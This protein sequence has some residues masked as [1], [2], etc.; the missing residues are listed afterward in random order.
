MYRCHDTHPLH[1]GVL[2]DLSSTEAQCG[3][4][5]QQLGYE[6]LCLLCDVGPVLI[7]KLILALLDAVKQVTL[8][9]EY[10]TIS[11]DT[12]QAFFSFIYLSFMLFVAVAVILWLCLYKLTELNTY[13]CDRRGGLRLEHGGWMSVPGRFCRFLPGPSHSRYH[14]GLWRGGCRSAG[15]RGSPQGSKGHSA[16]RRM[17][18]HRWTPPLLLEPCTLQSHTEKKRMEN[19]QA[20]SDCCIRY[21]HMCWLVLSTS[22]HR[23]Y[24][25]LRKG[26]TKRQTTHSPVKTSMKRR[27]KCAAA[28]LS[29]ISEIWVSVPNG[30][31]IPT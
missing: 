12:L 11:C 3:V 4:P 20:S 23:Y 18:P 26:D 24:Y 7:W 17:R 19:T 30:C 14:S 6:I 21:I 31:W 13:G 8:R 2:E 16:C 22:V 15:C 9:R 5:N 25:L 29:S 27:R 1:P 10:Y 28:L